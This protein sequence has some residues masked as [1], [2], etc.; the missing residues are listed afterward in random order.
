MF[1]TTFDNLVKFDFYS[2]MWLE[3]NMKFWKE[4]IEYA[5]K[6][7]VICLYCN[8]WDESPY[9]LKELFE[10]INSKYFRFAFDIGHAN[11]ISNL[12][13]DIWVETMKEYISYVAVHDNYG[14]KDAHLG[15]GKGNINLIDIVNKIN[16]NCK[17]VVWC[18][19]TF[20]KGDTQ[21]SIN[22]LRSFIKDI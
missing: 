10:Y 18:I 8:V 4:I 20:D 11:Y 12:S 6:K 16:N 2:E 14:D 15:I 5:E 1:S 22:L 3:R 7:N 9:L 13:L 21:E 17:D 19:Q